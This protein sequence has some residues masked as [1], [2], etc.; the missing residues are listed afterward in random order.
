M[1]QIEVSIKAEMERMGFDVSNLDKEALEELPKIV[2]KWLQ[3]RA[4]RSRRTM[5]LPEPS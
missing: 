2:N 4:S 5:P 3:N 1:P